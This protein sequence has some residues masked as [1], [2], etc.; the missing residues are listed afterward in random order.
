MVLQPSIIK[1]AEDIIP[2]DESYLQKICKVAKTGDDFVGIKIDY[3]NKIEVQ[4][5]MGFDLTGEDKELRKDIQKLIQ[6]FSIFNKQQLDGKELDQITD[7]SGLD[8]PINSYLLVI[9]NYLNYGY[10]V[11]S[12]PIY[13][14]S[15]RGKIDWPKTIR[16]QT[17]LIQKSKSG[18]FSFI[19]MVYYP[20]IDSRS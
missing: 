4:F 3:G 8:F 2:E 19:F 17:P 7:I 1:Q 9:E 6:T 11:E 14:T 12:D 10:Y 20:F 13:K 16:K 5:P 15:S 18:N